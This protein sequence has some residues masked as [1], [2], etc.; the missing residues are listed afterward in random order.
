MDASTAT[1]QAIL[2][3]MN[4]SANTKKRGSI[5]KLFASPGG[6]SITDIYLEQGRQPC[7]PK[8]SDDEMEIEEEG[9]SAPGTMDAR[10]SND[11]QESEASFEEIRATA[12]SLQDE[13]DLMHARYVLQS[14]L[15]RAFQAVERGTYDPSRMGYLLSDL[16]FVSRNLGDYEEAIDYYV[17]AIKYELMVPKESMATCATSKAPGNRR[18]LAYLESIAG[19]HIETRSH[20]SAL[21]TFKDVYDIQLECMG[22]HSPEVALTLHNLGLV[23]CILGNYIPSLNFCQ[24]SLRIN[25]ILVE[26]LGGCGNDRGDPCP[27]SLYRLLGDSLS[28]TGLV[29]RKLGQYHQAASSFS[30]AITIREAFLDKNHPDVTLMWYNMGRVQNEVG[31]P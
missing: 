27:T 4:N 26:S 12:S 17:Q 30:L 24:E 31:D 6:D 7:V 18:L 14:N 22:A 16:G 15:P 8:T 2:E 10:F 23:H 5:V 28:A 29:Y 9:V 25:L 11:Q 3:A 13:G 1:T 19:I 20:E 21:R